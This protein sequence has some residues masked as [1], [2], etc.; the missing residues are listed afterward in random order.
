[1]KIVLDTNVL[2]RLF[3][4]PRLRDEFDERWSRPMLYLSSIVAMELDAGCRTKAH[5]RALAGF[6]RPFESASRV[7]TP[8]HTCFREAG[9][10]LVGLENEGIGAVHLRQITNDV[11][12]A[13]STARAGAVVVTDNA[14]DFSRITKHRPVRWVVP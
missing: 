5:A 8:D 6:V 11:L 7:I 3:R 1:M 4:N 2:I 9:R 10:V 12:I 14:S 13:V